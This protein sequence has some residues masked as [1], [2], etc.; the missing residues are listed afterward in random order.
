MFP[1]PSVLDAP[2]E[3]VA[4]EFQKKISYRE[5]FVR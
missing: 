5:Q 4:V 1:I 3:D 2:A